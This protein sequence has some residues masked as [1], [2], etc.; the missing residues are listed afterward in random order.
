MADISQFMTKKENKTHDAIFTQSKTE[1]PRPHLG[2]SQI[3]HPC[4]RYLWLYHRWAFTQTISKRIQLLFERGEKEEKKVIRELKNISIKTYGEQKEIVT[5]WGHV[6]GHID[7]ICKG[8]LEAPKTSHLFECKTMADKYF[9]QIK[10]SRSV[11][12]TKPIYYSQCQAYMH[13][14]KLKRALFVAVN[15]NTDE[16]YIERIKYDKYHAN[17]LFMKADEIVTA[18]TLPPIEKPFKRTWYECKFCDA[19]DFCYH[20]KP[21]EINCRTCRYVE[22]RVDGVWVCR[23]IGRKMNPCEQ[24]VPCQHYEPIEG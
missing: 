22:K 15:K 10:K 5:A 19:Y 4:K 7:G 12:V 16:W 13:G 21:Y 8:V 17:A 18:E 20:E 6:K 2:L 14:L 11:K 23:D 3:G 24:A 9:N 1:L